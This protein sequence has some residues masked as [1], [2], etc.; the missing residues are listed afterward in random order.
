ME[1]SGDNLSQEIRRMP[2]VFGPGVSPRQGPDGRPFPSAAA[3]GAQRRTVLSV[4]ATSER[5]SL[6]A[7]LP[8]RVELAGEPRVR[9]SV[10]WLEDIGWLAGRDY[11]VL[12]V[13][14]P[15]LVAEKAGRLEGEFVAVLWENL[16]DPIITGREELGMAKV[17]AEI[18]DLARDGE[19]VSCKVSWGGFVFFEAEIR[20][21][22]ADPAAAGEY[23]AGKTI[24]HKYFPRTGDWGQ[25]DIDYLTCGEGEVDVVTGLER[26]EGRAKFVVATWDQLPTLSHIVNPLAALDLEIVEATL[27]VFRGSPS[28]RAQ[29]IID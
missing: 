4:L 19:Q 20:N 21:L 15:A 16:A 26:G 3:S 24:N 23:P 5:A 29:R 7:L 28:F 18:S 12:Q 25:A 8:E 11:A 9:I 13:Q 22:S 27:T 2:T 6:E 14:M 17:Y 1:Y 10:V